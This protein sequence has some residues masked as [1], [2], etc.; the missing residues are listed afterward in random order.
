MRRKAKLSFPS[1]LPPKGKAPRRG[2]SFP[3][4]G[5][6][7]IGLPVF[8]L[9]SPPG[10]AGVPHKRA[11]GGSLLR[12]DRSS[13]RARFTIGCQSFCVQMPPRASFPCHAS[14]SADLAYRS[15]GRPPWVFL[16]SRYLRT[17]VGRPRRVRS[18][19]SRAIYSAIGF[20]FPP[21]ETLDGLTQVEAESKHAGGSGASEKCQ[22]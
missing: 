4:G 11:P 14:E 15:A 9:G 8:P 17:R 18:L 7:P 1:A 22:F 10:P 2:A 12:G 13:K 3:F 6:G 19:I 21:G 16:L 5:R 20:G